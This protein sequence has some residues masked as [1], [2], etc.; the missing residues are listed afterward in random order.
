MIIPLLLH[1]TRGEQDQ[2]KGTRT[3]VITDQYPTTNEPHQ[4]SLHSHELTPTATQPSTL[5]F[6]REI[7]EELWVF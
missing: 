3:E 2:E 6:E 4:E 5:V 7:A 1:E